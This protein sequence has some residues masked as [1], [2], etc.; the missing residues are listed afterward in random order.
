MDNENK[1]IALESQDIE[2]EVKEVDFD[3]TE[4][5]DFYSNLEAAIGGA[6]TEEPAEAPELEVEEES[7]EV[8]E[9]A[10]E[11]EEAVVVGVPEETEQP[12][13]YSA[14]EE[15]YL[16]AGVDAALAE[17]I[18]QEF[19][20]DTEEVS[21]TE[22]KEPNKFMKIFKEI[23]TWTK[24]LVSVILV[25]LLSVGL[26][27]GTEGGRNLVYKAIT[28]MFFDNIR[29]D[30][31]DLGYISPIPELTDT[32]TPEPTMDPAQNLDTTPEPTTD[33]SQNPDETPGLT[34]EPT[35]T[36]EPTATPKP[37]VKIMD[38]EDVI[39]VLLLGEENIYGAKRGRT[40]AILLVSVNLNGG[41]L[42]IVSFQ[43]DLYVS[44]EGYA[45]DRLNASYAYGGA[46]L[47][48]DTIEKNFGVDIDSYVKVNFEGFE[49]IIDQL[50]GLEIS[51][52]ARESEYLNTT[53]YISKA[54]QRNTVAGTQTMT[55]S[56]VLGYCRV[57]YVPT[58][59]GLRDD[60]GRNYRH[61]VVLQAIFDKFKEKSFSELVTVMGQCFDYVSAPSSL[62][63]LAVDCLSAV[64][65]NKMFEI[66]TMQMPQ[67]GQYT[68]AI[69]A[70]KDVIVYYP[71]SVT[72][73]QDF[74]YGEE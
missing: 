60:R 45:D 72:L 71:E 49:N 1:E 31:D 51:L 21:S 16:F 54:S 37:P 27:F 3:P 47:I 55:G 64:I 38:D 26:L 29:E 73:L 6:E 56:Q 48:M 63:P 59:E 13:G 24:V 25:I 11:A 53:K 5:E 68:S 50:G 40:D 61:R 35:L 4:S 17:Q 57:R 41:P 66:E 28:S 34:E 15:D 20:K 2:P 65:E 74:L 46:S 39:N 14:V 19:G 70:K 58:A 18:E 8:K 69:I 62:E 44:I 9:E 36:P 33:P 43:R 23:P 12:G 32:P 52:T 42:K 22:E 30:P 7:I 10:I 67:S